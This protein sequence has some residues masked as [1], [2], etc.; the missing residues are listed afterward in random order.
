MFKRVA[1]LCAALML[2]PSVANAQSFPERPVTVIVPYAPGGN[3]DLAS[4]II[5]KRMEV[6]L[7]QP[8]II[9]N[10]AGAAGSVGATV[11][12]QAKPNGYTLMFDNIG[13][14][15]MN[16]HLYPTLPYSPE[17]D[18]ALIG[19]VVKSHNA[20]FVGPRV[21]AKTVQELFEQI[22]AEPGRFRYGSGGV[23]T[24]VHVFTE[25]MK[26]AANLDIEHIP[27]KSSGPAVIG[28]MAGETD[29]TVDGSAQNLGHVRAGKL[30]ALAMTSPNR[31]PLYPD[32]PTLA[33][34]VIPNFSAEAWS[35]LSAPA[36]TPSETIRILNNALNEALS[37]PEIKSQ[38]AGYGLTTIP[39]TPD[40]AVAFIKGERERW[41]KVIKDNNIRAQ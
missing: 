16:E 14:L 5:M 1:A 4:R 3:T 30:R 37:D 10:R 15:S 34:S 36:G 39:S 31:D 41:G 7:K 9:E 27:Y 18:F 6:T 32:V 28:L 8:L 19:M 12:A 22:R 38:L 23:G 21:K 17:R 2:A 33:E 26:S 35:A 25:Y 40:D 24:G 11:V 13:I 29:I 20:V